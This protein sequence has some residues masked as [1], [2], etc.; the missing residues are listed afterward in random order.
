LEGTGGS[1]IDGTETWNLGENSHA[2]VRSKMVREESYKLATCVGKRA[3]QQGRLQ[4]KKWKRVF[5]TQRASKKRTVLKKLPKRGGKKRSVKCHLSRKGG[6]RLGG[7]KKR[8]V[9][10][11]APGTG[12]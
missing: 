5:K 11:E 9:F 4:N 6:E 8:G 1:R 7:R 10:G 12:T 2:V 3:I